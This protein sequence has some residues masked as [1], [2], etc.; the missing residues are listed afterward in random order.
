[1]FIIDLIVM[2]M[3]KDGWEGIQFTNPERFKLI[4]LWPL[5]LIVFIRGF[6][7]GNE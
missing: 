3:S 6:F 5:S 7:E 4:L 1:M 2:K